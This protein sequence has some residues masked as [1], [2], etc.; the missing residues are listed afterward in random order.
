MK[1]KGFYLLKIKRTTGQNQRELVSKGQRG[2]WNQ[3]LRWSLLSDA[4]EAGEEASYLHWSPP[5]R[6][7]LHAGV[8]LPQSVVPHWGHDRAAPRNQLPHVLPGFSSAQLKVSVGWKC[9]CGG[10]FQQVRPVAEGDSADSDTSDS[11]H[12]G[13][14]FSLAVNPLDVAPVWGHLRQHGSWTRTR[15][16]LR[17]CADRESSAGLLRD[18]LISLLSP[19]AAAATAHSSSLSCR[20]FQNQ[21][22]P[23]ISPD[24]SSLPSCVHQQSRVC[25]TCQLSDLLDWKCIVLEAKGC[26]TK[27]AS[28]R[29]QAKTRHAACTRQL[30]RLHLL[31]S[32]GITEALVGIYGAPCW[33]IKN[34][35]LIKNN[36]PFWNR[37][38]KNKH[39]QIIQSAFLNMGECPNAFSRAIT[40]KALSHKSTGSSQKYLNK[41]KYKF[42]NS[43]G[44]RDDKCS[45]IHTLYVSFKSC[46][47]ITHVDVLSRNTQWLLFLC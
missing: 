31:G 34:K 47:I 14:H 26:Y 10:T 23:T 45:H 42:F 17:A 2:S 44:L 4:K 32:A 1:R 22:R 20:Y 39:Q 7:S 33:E 5:G 24:L 29:K 46:W 43:T 18:W 19:P 36:R 13:Q 25:M 3:R 35:M 12:R 40:S 37:C 30:S 15:L 27:H 8:V 9:S 21:E 38:V 16:P 28:N 41:M 6:S 11:F